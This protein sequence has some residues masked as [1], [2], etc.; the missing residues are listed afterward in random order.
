MINKQQIKE[1]MDKNYPGFNFLCSESSWGQNLHIMDKEGRSYSRLYWYYDDGKVGYIEGLFV[2][3]T[4]RH[5]GL[6]KKNIEVL[7]GI[8][9]ELGFKR[10][11]LRVDNDRAE[12]WYKNLG[13]HFNGYDEDKN[14]K[15]Y[16][17]HLFEDEKDETKTN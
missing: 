13:Y 4:D 16:C 9:K 11:F 6:G 3:Q 1:F 12:K 15:W 14:Y 17:K 7:E 10:I 2:K 8:S 5:K